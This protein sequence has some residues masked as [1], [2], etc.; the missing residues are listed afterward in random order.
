[1]RPAVLLL[2]VPMLLA[3]LCYSSPLVAAAAAGAP[4]RA[5]AGKGTG[6]DR[7][8]Q[9]QQ[10]QQQQDKTWLEVSASA[11]TMHI[12]AVHDTATKAVT[13]VQA[14]AEFQYCDATPST[15]Q[16]SIDNGSCTGAFATY[17]PCQAWP[18]YNY[19]PC[20]I[21]LKIPKRQQQQQQQQQRQQQQQISPAGGFDVWLDMR[22]TGL[23]ARCMIAR[24]SNS[25]RMLQDPMLTTTTTTA[26]IEPL[27]AMPPVLI[28]QQ[29]E[30]AAESPSPKPI[31]LESPLP[32]F[33]NAES[34]GPYP[35]IPGHTPPFDSP[36]PYPSTEPQ[37]SLSPGP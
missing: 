36:K 33:D 37:P 11:A 34:P 6:R 2:A 13:Q 16:C 8:R 22:T 29:G 17:D 21:Q 7:P 1:M 15:T 32:Y 18:Q 28:Q 35:D 23:P 19:S 14:T 27:V 5:L 25:R 4:G 31:Y 10:Q 3:C 26:T 20:G 24:R 30:T 12:V 9:R